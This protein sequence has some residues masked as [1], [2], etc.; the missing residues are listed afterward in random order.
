MSGALDTQG[1]Q[2]AT[3]AEL[4][5]DVRT[6]CEAFQQTVARHP[7]RVGLRTPGDGVSISWGEY[8]ERVR[9]LAEGLAAIG[10]GA[11]DTV[12]IM[13]VN[14]PEFNLVDAAALHLGAVPFSIYNTCS[15]EQVSYLF[16]NA[17]NRVVVSEEQFLATIREAGVA[18]IERVIC[19]EEGVAA[20]E[21]LGER[22]LTLTE[23]ES[24]QQPGFDFEASWRGVTEEDLVTICYTSG[25]TGPPKGVELSHA[26]VL[27][28]CRAAGAVIPHEADGRVISYLPH[29]HMADRY[30]THYVSL[31]YGTQVTLLADVREIGSTLAE[32][33]PTSFGSVPRVWEKLK[34]GLEAAIASEPDP[35]RK[36]AVQWAIDT[37]L[38]RVRAEQA[39][40]EPSAELLAEAEQADDLVL[41]KLRERLGLDSTRMLYAGAAPTPIDVLEFFHAIGLPI[42]ELWGMS[43]LT[44]V[45]TCNPRERPRIGT[46][47]PPLPGL[48]VRVAQDGE[49]LCRGGMVMRGYRSDP[50]QTAQTIDADGWLHTGDIAAIDADGYVRIVDRK[51]E[52]IINA[53]GKNM[54]PANIESQLKGA[55][56]LIG[57]AIAIGDRRPY[58]VALI[59]LDPDGASAWGTE[60][61]LEDASPATLAELPELR[62]EIARAVAEANT[63]LSRVEQIKRHAILAEDWLPGGDELTPTMKLKRKPIAEKYGAQIEALYG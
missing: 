51:K 43:E 42:C 18:E 23:L 58:N 3:S 8:G 22:G 2:A 1:T 56:P 54:S 31:L 26:N 15:A 46:V 11:G 59:V 38:R 20:M 19:V 36:Q 61:G 24:L 55:S 27:A 21:D 14:R 52:L 6:V 60:H 49:L 62:E 33:R 50:E 63:H 40:E 41:S 39:G 17:E 35:A 9:R 25:T 5:A 45:G 16:S 37:G 48:E 34:A 32:A 47:G 7:E 12:G 28:E 29:A 44:C 4:A 30:S 57:Q 13:L 10:V 53:A